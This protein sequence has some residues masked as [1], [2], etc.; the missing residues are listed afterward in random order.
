MRINS[1]ICTLEWNS[2]FIGQ[3][4]NGLKADENGNCTE[5]ETKWEQHRIARSVVRAINGNFF[6]ASK[7]A[8]SVTTFK[9]R[10]RERGWEGGRVG[11]GEEGGWREEGRGGGREG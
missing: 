4:R 5:M 6:D 1:M 8:C 9:R 10:G 11:G 2:L 3:N 7:N